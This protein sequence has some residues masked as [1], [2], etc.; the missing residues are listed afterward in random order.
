M[1]AAISTTGT[2]TASSG[3]AVPAAGPYSLY[4]ARRLPNRRLL[5]AEID[6]RQQQHR[7]GA[8]D[9]HPAPAELF[10]QQPVGDGRQ[11]IAEGVSRPN[12]PDIRPR[13]RSGIVSI[14]SEEATPQIPPIATPYSTRSRKNSIN[15]GAAAESSS[16]AEKNTMLSIR[17]GLRPNFSAALPKI[18]A[19]MGR[20][21]RVSRIA[22]VTSSRS[23]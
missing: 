22:V 4:S 7:R 10:K 19:P 8:N 13:E 16:K 23:T 12:R 9:K 14:A 18:S 21:A 3:Y 1:K 2:G 11:Q 6:K 15:D 20:T 5:D 17:I